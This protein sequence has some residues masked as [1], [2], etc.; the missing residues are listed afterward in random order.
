[1]KPIGT[2]LPTGLPAAPATSPA[3]GPAPPPAP[4]I[5][6]N[7]RLRLDPA[8]GIVVMEF[9]DAEGKVARSAPSAAQLE[10]YRNAQRGFGVKP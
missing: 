3:S 8:L 4:P 5:G 7:P 1:M 9:L 10:A 6:P 2:Y